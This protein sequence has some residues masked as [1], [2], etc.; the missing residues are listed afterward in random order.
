MIEKKKKYMLV[1]IHIGEVI[2]TWISFM[3]AKTVENDRKEEEIHI[4]RWSMSEKLFS[5]MDSFNGK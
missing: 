3:T 1:N 2:P 4:R 5:G